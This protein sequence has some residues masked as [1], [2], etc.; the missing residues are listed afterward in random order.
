MRKSREAAR[1]ALSGG[2]RDMRRHRDL[3]LVSGALSGRIELNIVVQAEE[4]DATLKPY[5]SSLSETKSFTAGIEVDNRAAWD[6][7]A[8]SRVVASNDA[9]GKMEEIQSR[10]KGE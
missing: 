6:Y 7:S 8:H 5:A 4:I 1:A 3:T 2:H 9:C 10:P